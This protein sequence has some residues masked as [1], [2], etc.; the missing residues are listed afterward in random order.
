[1]GQSGVQRRTA[2][3]L[4]ISMQRF[5]ITQHVGR[6]WPA[7]HRRREDTSG[8]VIIAGEGKSANVEVTAGHVPGTEGR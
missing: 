8:K 5:P 3:L 7:Y 4:T 2:S 6:G 1:M